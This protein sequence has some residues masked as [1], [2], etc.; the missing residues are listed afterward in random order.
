[1]DLLFPFKWIEAWI[2]KIVHE[3]FTLLGMSDGPGIAWVLS[4]VGLTV[5]VRI[6]I[7]PLFKKQ[8]RAQRAQQL[9]QPEL[10]KLQKKYKGKRDTYSQQRMQAEMQAIYKDAGTSPFASCMPLLVQM[11]IFFALFRLLQGLSPM[12]NGTKDAIGPLDQKLASDIEASTVFGAPLSASFREPL[13]GGGDE[14]TVKIVAMV[15]VI[16]MTV[17]MFISQRMILTKNMPEEAKSSDN[18]MYRTQQMMIWIFPVIFLV[19]GIAFPIGVLVYWVVSNVW[20]TGQQL[21]MITVVPAP[22][23][24]AYH[25]KKK[26]DRER[27]IKK[28]LP[29]EEPKEVTAEEE[30]KAGQRQQPVGKNRAK[31]KGL[32]KEEAQ[33]L[34]ESTDNT[35]EQPTQPRKK[36]SKKQRQAE[37]RKQGQTSTDD[38]RDPN[39]R[40][41]ARAAERKRQRNNKNKKNRGKN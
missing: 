23:S 39:A 16:L 38:S 25:A 31:R 8:I 18:P 4:I 5:I 14:M 1:M 40:A 29:P 17:T 9:I 13:I 6:L 26:R 19:S 34:P 20:A 35:A 28:G 11:P 21:Y 2:M 22:G 33:K 37:A 36:K 24:E 12:A 30:T 3:G 32:S 10:K 27:R 41:R 15:L 7:I